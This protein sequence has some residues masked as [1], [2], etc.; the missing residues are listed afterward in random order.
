MPKHN[1]ISTPVY[2]IDDFN[3]KSDHPSFYIGNLREHLTKHEFVSRPHKH[4]F[5]LVMQV[6][7][8][9]GTH[10]IDF[11]NYPVVPGLFFFL[12][13]GQVHTWSLDPNVDGYILFFTRDFYQMQ[14]NPN[15]V[16][17]FPFFHS[18]NSNASLLIKGDQGVDLLMKNLFVEYKNSERPDSRILRAHLDLLLLLLARKYKDR[19]TQPMASTSFKL[20]R[21]E[22]EIEKNF[23]KYKKPSDYADILNLSAPYLNNLCKQNL[24]KTLTELIQERIVLEAKR[25]FAYTELTANQVSDRLDFSDSSYFIRFFRKNTGLTPDQFKESINRTG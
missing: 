3:K 23:I 21:L 4:D 10:S 14:L 18:L 20:R 5:Y 9:K 7:Q 12:T 6:T 25:L 16:V 24:G 2:C 15:S 22:Q 11:Q 1:A 17:E 19:H 13:P 8:G